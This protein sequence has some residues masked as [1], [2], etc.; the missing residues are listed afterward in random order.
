MGKRPLYGARL[1]EAET[2]PTTGRTGGNRLWG[3]DFHERECRKRGVKF[4]R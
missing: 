3:V 2:R 4:G 1:R